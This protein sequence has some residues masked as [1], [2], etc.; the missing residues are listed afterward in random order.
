MSKNF[1]KII[2]NSS[3][4]R[5]SEKAVS[6]MNGGVRVWLPKTQIQSIVET[7]DRKTVIF[8]ADW[9]VREKGLQN[10][11]AVVNPREVFADKFAPID[12]ALAKYHATQ[13][14]SGVDAKKAVDEI[15][16]RGEKIEPGTPAYDQFI[17]L[18]SRWSDKIEAARLEVLAAIE[19]SGLTRVTLIAA[20]FNT[21]HDGTWKFEKNF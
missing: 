16:A 19:A 14:A 18:A 1:T 17:E 7:T 3:I 5:Q 8:V 11:A 4:D 21:W 20:G 6:F 9:L 10:L 2:L 15:T 13:E 12:A